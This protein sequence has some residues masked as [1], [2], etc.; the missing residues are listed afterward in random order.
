[1]AERRKFPAV[2]CGSAKTTVCQNAWLVSSWGVDLAGCNH[3]ASGTG[4][5]QSPLTSGTTERPKQFLARLDRIRVNTRNGAYRVRAGRAKF[6]LHRPSPTG[7]PIALG[8]SYFSIDVGRIRCRRSITAA[9]TTLHDAA[10]RSTMRHQTL[11]NDILFWKPQDTVND[12]GRW[13]GNGHLFRSP[14]PSRLRFPPTRSSDFAGPWPLDVGPDAASRKDVSHAA[15]P[16][17]MAS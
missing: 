6:S 2:C 13:S 11:E 12:N 17:V 4:P 8:T 1:M 5:A 15:A 16:T 9:E 14:P 3:L 10:I 7:V